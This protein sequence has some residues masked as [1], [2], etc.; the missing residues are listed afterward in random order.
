MPLL[1]DMKP[2]DKI[3]IN[4][5]VIESTGSHSRLMVHNQAAILR[6]REVMTEED[7]CTPA[8][9]IYFALQCAYIFPVEEEKYIA[10][11]KNL[12]NDYETACPS[13]EPITSRIRVL[14]SE[15]QLYKALRATQALLSHEYELAQ[16]FNAHMQRQLDEGQITDPDHP[17]PGHSV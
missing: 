15:G 4:G 14:V 13:A 16:A 8:S 9:R 5:A 6:G 1:I 3:I 12:L 7:A 17:S 11:F 10:V 2:G